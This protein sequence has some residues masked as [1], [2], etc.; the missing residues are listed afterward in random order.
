MKKTLALFVFASALGVSALVAQSPAAG[1]NPA[2]FVQHRVNYLT[3]LLNLTSAQQQQATAIFTSAA[4]AE[5]SVHSSMKTA[6]Q[7]L[8]TAVQANDAA[9]IEQ[10][11]TT[12][13]NL[14]AQTTA[15][16]AKAEAAFYQILTA[17]QQAKL[18]Q[19]ESQNHGRMGGGM[20]PESFRGRF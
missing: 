8:N 20:G 3:T 9:G 18:T 1:P 17:A 14:T 10:A 11:A 2:N 7:S 16:Q 12:I 19:F 6:R 5:T 13:G 15:N 4:T